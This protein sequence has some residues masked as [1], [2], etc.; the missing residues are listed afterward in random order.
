LAVLLVLVSTMAAE[1]G[2]HRK[3]TGGMF[4][5][6]DWGDRYEVWQQYNVQETEPWVD[7]HGI[8]HNAIGQVNYKIYN[9]RMGGWRHVQTTP[10]CIAFGE[11]LDG[12]SMAQ[13][14]L[15]IDGVRGWGWGEPGEHS[16]F[17]IRD[18]GT[19]GRDGDQWNMEYYQVNPWIE[20][21]PVDVPPPD[22]TSSRPDH[23]D[24]WWE[25]SRGNLTIH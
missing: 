24:L 5:V 12:T 2:A 14:V 21:W 1:A 8:V 13:V 18:G 11:D 19:P 7:E 9:E 4:F 6:A 15:R 22:C 16:I 23:M 3:L 20:F 17:Y 25:I 10:I